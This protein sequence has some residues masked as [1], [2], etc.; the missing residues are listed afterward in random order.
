MSYTKRALE[1]AIYEMADKHGIRY[2]IAEMIWE[3]CDGD[4]EFYDTVCR[5]FREVLDEVYRNGHLYQV[6]SL[7]DV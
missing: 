7:K 6:T 2:D 1:S 5:I 4:I 3:R